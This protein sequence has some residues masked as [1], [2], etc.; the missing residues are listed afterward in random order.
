[1]CP[2]CQYENGHAPNCIEGTHDPKWQIQILLNGV[3]LGMFGTKN[4]AELIMRLKDIIKL[5]P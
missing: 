2:V 3:M 4:R 5:L 1:M